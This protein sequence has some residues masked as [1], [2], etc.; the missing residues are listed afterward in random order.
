MQIR[1]IHS[2]GARPSRLMRYVCYPRQPIFPSANIKMRRGHGAR[3]TTRRARGIYNVTTSNNTKPG[4]SLF[5]AS[6]KG[7]CAP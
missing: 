5:L 4:I 1:N 3:I 7:L 6:S 2:L